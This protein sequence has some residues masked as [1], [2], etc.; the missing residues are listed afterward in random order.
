MSTSVQVS[1]LNYH[2]A[3]IRTSG[4]LFAASI[5]LYKFS[6]G[7][8]RARG[9]IARALAVAALLSVAWMLWRGALEYDAMLLGERGNMPPERFDS[10]R[11]WEMVSHAMA[12]AV[13]CVAAFT[14][15]YLFR[16]A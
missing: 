2:L 4:G 10:L 7:F 15:A 5:A 13:A 16:S 12:A 9:L 11:S 14:A 6:G 3:Q 8:S 1:L